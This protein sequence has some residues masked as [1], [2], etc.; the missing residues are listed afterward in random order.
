MVSGTGSYSPISNDISTVQL[1]SF[2]FAS[3]GGRPG[4]TG[5]YP[6]NDL[7]PYSQQVGAG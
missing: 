1:S 7:P 3:V 6:L 5:W 2:N 4:H